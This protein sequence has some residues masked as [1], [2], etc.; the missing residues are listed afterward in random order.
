MSCITCNKGTCEP[1]AINLVTAKK[2]TRLR[3][4]CSASVVTGEKEGGEKSWET[5]R[6]RRRSMA[7]RR[8]R[9]R[10]RWRRRPVDSTVTTRLISLFLYA[11]QCG[12][13]GSRRTLVSLLWASPFMFLWGFRSLLFV[14]FLLFFRFWF[15]VSSFIFIFSLFNFYDWKCLD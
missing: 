9:R 8:R 14:R 11:A 7:V 13:V 15:L 12:A 2:K 6:H 1:V 5:T 3:V 4:S 10:R